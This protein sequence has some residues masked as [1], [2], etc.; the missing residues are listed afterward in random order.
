MDEERQKAW[1][2]KVSTENR[3]RAWRR[4]NHE[5]KNLQSTGHPHLIDAVDPNPKVI[6]NSPKKR[7]SKE[8]RE[9]L[10]YVY[11]SYA[12]DGKLGRQEARHAFEMKSEHHDD[13]KSG[14]RV[15]GIKAAYRSSKRS[16]KNLAEYGYVVLS[17]DAPRETFDMDYSPNRYQPVLYITPT[18]AAVEKGKEFREQD[19]EPTDPEE[20]RRRH[21][22]VSAAMAEAM[23]GFKSLL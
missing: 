16:A 9:Y 20:I 13:Y 8:Q 3:Y 7:F 4:A 2:N 1:L 19:G 17:Y 18:M 5:P 21:K 15:Q 11:G 10:K 14:D 6:S 22:E 12:L 23:K